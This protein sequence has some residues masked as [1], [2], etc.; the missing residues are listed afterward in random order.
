MPY[1]NKELKDA[2]NKMYKQK[3]RWL[4]YAQRMMKNGQTSV[5]QNTYDHVKEHLSATYLSS[6]RIMGSLKDIVMNLS[7]QIK[8]EPV[9]EKPVEHITPVESPKTHRQK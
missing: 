8:I 2:N 3:N 6:L 7:K 5:N 4:L 9:V 1:T